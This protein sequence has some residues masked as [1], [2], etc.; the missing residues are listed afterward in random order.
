LREISNASREGAKKK[1][2]GKS[3]IPAFAG[4]TKE[5]GSGPIFR[6]RVSLAGASKQA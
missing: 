4:M 3:G 5:G 6:A 2:E 1:E